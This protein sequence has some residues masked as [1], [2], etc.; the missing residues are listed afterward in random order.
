MINSILFF[1]FVLT[2]YGALEYYGW[3]AIKTVVPVHHTKLAFWIYWGVAFTVFALFVLNRPFLH[4]YMTRE[5]SSYFGVLF[6]I[7]LLSKFIVLLF[8]LPGDV[9]SGIKAVYA[10][11][12]PP[13]VPTADGA[14]PRS[15]FL[16]RIALLTAA[17]PAGTL[18]YGVL[19]NA[20]NYQF[21]R[22][23]IKF[24]NLPPAFDGFKIVQLSDIHAGSF[25]RTEPIEQVVAK[26]NA[27]DPDLILFT[28]DLVNNVAT[29]M[30]P[31][32]SIFGRLKAKH[33]VYSITGNHDYGDYVHWDTEEEKAANFE[34]FKAVHQKMGWQLL[35][36]E[37]RK[38]EKDGQYISLLGVENWG[39]GRFAKYGKFE[40]AVNGLEKDSF[41]V[42]MSHDPSSWD[43]RIRTEYPDIDLTLSGHTH[44]AQFGI[45][46]KWL[47]W[48]PSQYIY[49]QWAG[50]YE[51]VSPIEQRGKQFLYVNRGFGFLGYP[52]RVGILPE[53][54]EITLRSA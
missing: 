8:L 38:L 12:S 33:G 26:I 28:G 3:Q 20:Y 29:E 2:F 4:N 36:N 31:F 51:A 32:I 34:A 19:A 14:I 42:L 24:P 52:G 25:T 30:A 53:V 15:E 6:M 9:W 13:A 39:G 48:S 23:T 10:K 5:M 11:F 35:L 22:T 16:S 46:N 37:N 1:A 18:V 45:E 47:K 43:M 17:V 7:L 44:G 49:K 27:L 54:A 41:K 21:H 50:L 40:D